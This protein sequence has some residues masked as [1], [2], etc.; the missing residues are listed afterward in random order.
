MNKVL[1][2]IVFIYCVL[3]LDVFHH[4]NQSYAGTVF[5]AGQHPVNSV[6][7]GPQLDPLKPAACAFVTVCLCLIINLLLYKC[8]T[9]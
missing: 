8:R 5:I 9:S 1:I 2:E 6:P 7:T 4:L 3:S